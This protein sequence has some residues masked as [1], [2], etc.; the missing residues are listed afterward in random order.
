MFSGRAALGVT[1]VISYRDHEES[2]AYP[3]LDL[4]GTDQRYHLFSLRHHHSPSSSHSPYVVP[5][6]EIGNIV[7][8]IHFHLS[9]I[10]PIPNTS[11]TPGTDLTYASWTTGN[12]SKISRVNSFEMFNTTGPESALDFTP[13]P[14]PPAAIPPFLPE[15]RSNRSSSNLDAR[16]GFCSYASASACSKAWSLAC[17]GYQELNR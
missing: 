6:I 11:R 3:N 14:V 2:R 15:S 4:R 7:T 10:S 8:R 12:S 17:C 5:I 16:P 9:I 1:S 13:T